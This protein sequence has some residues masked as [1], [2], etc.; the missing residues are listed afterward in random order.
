MITIQKPG[1]QASVKGPAEWFTGNVRMDPA[2]STEEPARVQVATVT[3][4]PAART[5]W[6]NHPLGQTLL[7]TAGCGIIQA[8]GGPAQIIRPGDVIW[9]PPGIKHWHGALSTVAMS[10]ISI[11]EKI[12]GS[13]VNWMQHV[14]DQEYQNGCSQCEK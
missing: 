12:N 14:T 5:A 2:I 11:T 10:H 3:F 8:E 6:H 7:V 9:T 13:S 1:S 4:E